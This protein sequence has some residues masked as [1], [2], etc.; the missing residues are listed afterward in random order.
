MSPLRFVEVVSPFIDRNF[1][2][3]IRIFLITASILHCRQ[4][5]SIMGYQL[6]EMFKIRFYHGIAVL[7]LLESRSN[8]VL[9]APHQYRRFDRFF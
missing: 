9:L 2:F 6:Q 7:Q 4:S 1:A 5:S 8:P 3:H